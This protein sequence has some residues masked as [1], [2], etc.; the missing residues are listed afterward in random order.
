M[1]SLIYYQGGA[2]ELQELL[3]EGMYISVNSLAFKDERDFSIMKR[4]PLNRIMIET[5]APFCKIKY[6]DAGFKLLSSE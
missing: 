4:I 1:Y 2:E 3:D 5:D 6:G